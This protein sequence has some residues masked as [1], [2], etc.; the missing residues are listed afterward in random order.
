MNSFTNNS[1]ITE[2]FLNSDIINDNSL[3]IYENVLICYY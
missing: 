2:S 1:F 3:Y